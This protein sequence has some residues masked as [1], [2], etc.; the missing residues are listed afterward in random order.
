MA[1]ILPP[2]TPEPENATARIQAL[3]EHQVWAWPL[4]Y[5][6]TYL[7]AETHS[8]IYHL[9]LEA[10]GGWLTCGAVAITEHAAETERVILLRLRTPTLARER[11]RIL[12]ETW[13]RLQ[14]ELSDRKLP[15]KALAELEPIHL[16]LLDRPP[17]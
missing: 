11:V 2:V 12:T 7:D 1:I 10:L 13:Q 16:A 14:G 15:L 3:A 17:I 8:R 6:Y 9:V 5:W 4:Q